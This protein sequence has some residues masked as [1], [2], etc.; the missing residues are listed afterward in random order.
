MNNSS[1]LSIRQ[2]KT[3]LGEIGFDMNFIANI[4]V[5]VGHLTEFL[6]HK[7]YMTGFTD[8]CKRLGIK[9]D[10]DYDPSKVLDPNATDEKKQQIQK[11]FKTRL[12]KV[13]DNTTV[14]TVALYYSDWLKSYNQKMIIPTRRHLQHHWLIKLCLFQAM[15]LIQQFPTQTPPPRDTEQ[16]LL[17]PTNH[18]RRSSVFNAIAS[19]FG[20]HIE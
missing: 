17:L 2:C 4:C 1:G 19:F 8:V 16:I 12:Q 18:R 5:G 6:V 20:K 7:E 14:E 11:L 10:T 13:I 9:Y 15:L 3:Y